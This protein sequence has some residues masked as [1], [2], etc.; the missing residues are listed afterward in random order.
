MKLVFLTCAQSTAVD[1]STQRLSLFHIVEQ[2]QS[3]TFPASLQGLVLVAMF[4]KETGDG[5]NASLRLKIVLGDAVLIE[6]PVAFSFQGRTKGRVLAAIN[7][8]AIPGPGIL[9]FILLSGSG[10]QIGS[11]EAAVEESVPAASIAATGRPSQA[12]AP[13]AASQGPDPTTS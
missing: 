13:T 11:W 9:S 12:N 10:G 3:A 2:I 5:D 1:A 8:L 7:G 4:A 6:T